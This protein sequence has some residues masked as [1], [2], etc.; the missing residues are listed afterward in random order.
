MNKLDSLGQLALTTFEVEIHLL[1]NLQKDLDEA[2]NECCSESVISECKKR[3]EVAEKE[4]SLKLFHILL[5]NM[6]LSGKCDEAL[7]MVLDLRENEDL[8][9]DALTRV[10]V[11]RDNLQKLLNTYM[12]N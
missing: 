11:Q 10:E 2:F 9:N 1:L 7:T 12:G 6:K 3:I 8:L 5:E 4:I